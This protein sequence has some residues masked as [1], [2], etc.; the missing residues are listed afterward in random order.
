MEIPGTKHEILNKSKFI[1]GHGGERP[2]FSG[3][4]IPWIDG[5][6]RPGT[7]TSLG[8]PRPLRGL[9]MTV[10]NAYA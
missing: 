3:T 5:G 8:L 7:W 6:D 4:A 1:N 9:A 2:D 10:H